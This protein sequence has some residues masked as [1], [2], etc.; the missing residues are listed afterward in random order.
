[1]P[2]YRDCFLV[3]I[4]P[5][6]KRQPPNKQTLII[7]GFLWVILILAVAHL[8]PFL[9]RELE[10]TSQ[11]KPPMLQC[12]TLLA[13]FVKQDYWWLE[14]DPASLHRKRSD[15]GKGV[16]SSQGRGECIGR[17]KV[18]FALWDMHSISVIF[19]SVTLIKTN[20]IKC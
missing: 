16:K 2:A 8:S 10:L 11:S 1:M 13:C 5:V 3:D 20:T 19:W 15:L 14:F 6:I 4:P 7:L 18:P 9:T 17:V 12:C